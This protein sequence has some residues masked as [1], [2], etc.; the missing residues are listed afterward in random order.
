MI[1][2]AEGKEDAYRA[3]WPEYKT[4]I[5]GYREARTIIREITLTQPNTLADS[6]NAAITVK[7]DLIVAV[8]GNNLGA[9]QGLK[10]NGPIG[11]KDLALIRYLG[12]REPD[13]DK[14]VYTTNLKYLDLYNAELKADDYYFQLKGSNRKIDT[15]NVV[16][17]DMLWNCDNLQLSLIHI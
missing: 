2:V 17:K 15:D 13:Y 3:A 1:Y 11:G 7:D 10:I 5:Q 9:I 4:H 8:G 6:L 16:P 14:P 12:G